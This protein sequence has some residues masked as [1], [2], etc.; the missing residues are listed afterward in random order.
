MIPIIL[1]VKKNKKQINKKEY[2]W[3]K[4]IEFI[5]SLVISQFQYVLQFEK[6]PVSRPLNLSNDQ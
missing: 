6:V 3:S 1:F 4:I 2:N 5:W